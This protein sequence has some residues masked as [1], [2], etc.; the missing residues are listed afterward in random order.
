[1]PALPLGKVRAE[2]DTPPPDRFVADHHA[3]LE[4]Q[5]FDIPQAHLKPAIPAHRA[6]D[7]EF[8]KTM[9]MVK[10]LWCLHRLN[11]RASDLNVTM[12]LENIV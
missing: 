9:A 7:D 8:R 5:L 11:L 2:L 6:T 12:P 3:A 1:M 4:E 10:R